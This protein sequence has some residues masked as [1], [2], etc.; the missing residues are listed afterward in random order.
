[1]LPNLFYWQDKSLMK[2]DG[3]LTV[4]M[5][6]LSQDMSVSVASYYKISQ[7]FTGPHEPQGVPIYYHHV[8]IQKLLNTFEIY[9][10]CIPLSHYR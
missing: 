2:T 9:I 10:I 1:M 5:C 4:I 8:L 6:S 3:R 7:G